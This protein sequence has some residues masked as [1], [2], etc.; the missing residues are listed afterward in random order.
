MDIFPFQISCS[1]SSIK[2]PHTGSKLTDVVVVAVRCQLLKSCIQSIKIIFVQATRTLALEDVLGEFLGVLR[3]HKLRVVGRSDV[4]QSLY[5]CRSICWL[6]WRVVDRVS[7]YFANIEVFFDFGHL[8][9]L[10]SVCDSPNFVRGG[11]VTVAKGL[12]MRSLNERN[13]SSGCL[14]CT[15]VVLAGCCVR[16]MVIE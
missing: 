6:K 8:F 11:V 12:P 1:G 13:Y 2:L 14:G 16:N 3:T 7:V 4:D 15:S 5:S 9:G 10:D